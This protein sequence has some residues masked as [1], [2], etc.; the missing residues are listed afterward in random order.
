V[1]YRKEQFKFHQDTSVFLS[2]GQLT[3][4]SGCI[5]YILRLRR[6]KRRGRQSKKL[7]ADSPKG[8]V[9]LGFFTTGKNVFVPGPCSTVKERDFTLKAFD[10]TREQPAVEDRS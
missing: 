6:S 4:L 2:F 7:T 3:T 10:K 9:M 8:R 1:S 5:T